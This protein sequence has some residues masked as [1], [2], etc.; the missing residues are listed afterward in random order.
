MT[1]TDA[2]IDNGV[3]VAALIEART[4]LTEQPA[5]AQFKWW[6]P[7]SLTPVHMKSGYADGQK[8]ENDADAP[9][10]ASAAFTGV[11][12]VPTPS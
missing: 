11:S 3:N 5:G 12:D 1:I 9:G 7:A 4:A 2:P 6:N 8:P 10:N